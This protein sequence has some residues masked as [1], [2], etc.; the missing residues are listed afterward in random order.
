MVCI[1]NFCSANTS[2]VINN[3]TARPQISPHS[4]AR[5]HVLGNVMEAVSVA[6]KFKRLGRPDP[7]GFNRTNLN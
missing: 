4:K 6:V 3:N 1:P 7:Q 5:R 2:A